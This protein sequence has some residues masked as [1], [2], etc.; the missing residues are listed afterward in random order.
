MNFEG[1]QLTGRATYAAFV[2]AVRTILVSLVDKRGFTP[3]AI[4]GRAKDPV[5]LKKKLAQ[6]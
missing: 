4:T 6:D 2:D 3:H 1:Y 5:S